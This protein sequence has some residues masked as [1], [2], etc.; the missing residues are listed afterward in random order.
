ML[1]EILKK[2]ENYNFFNIFTC[3]KLN[4]PTNLFFF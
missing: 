1:L 2:L 4:K 3:M